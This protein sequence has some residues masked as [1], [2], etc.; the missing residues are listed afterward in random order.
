MELC[1]SQ[2]SLNAIILYFFTHITITNT[3]CYYNN[4]DLKFF[5]VAFKDN[6]T[7]IS[8][9]IEIISFIKYAMIAALV[10]T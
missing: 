5:V 2:S 4:S 6:Y 9:K 3:D 7:E 10:T 1:D 8:I